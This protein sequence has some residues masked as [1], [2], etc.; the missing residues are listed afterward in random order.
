M[1][2]TDQHC[3]AQCFEQNDKGMP[4]SQHSTLPMTNLCIHKMLFHF[5]IR[6]V[7]QPI[8]IRIIW[9]EL[10]Y[11]V[12][13]IVTPIYPIDVPIE[14]HSWIFCAEVSYGRTPWIP[15]SNLHIIGIGKLFPINK[16]DDNEENC[17]IYIIDVRLVLSI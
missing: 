14:M 13:F 8:N 12:D 11:R 4:T 7:Q 9:I 10:C 15:H 16:Q 1:H 2:C 17:S 5:I 6:R 3:L